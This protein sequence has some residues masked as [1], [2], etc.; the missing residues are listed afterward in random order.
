LWHTILFLQFFFYNL[1]DFL[2]QLSQLSHRINWFDFWEAH[3][4]FEHV[5]RTCRYLSLHTYRQSF[6]CDTVSRTCCSTNFVVDYI[7]RIFWQRASLSTLNALG[8]NEGVRCFPRVLLLSR[9]S[10]VTYTIYKYNAIN[11]YLFYTSRSM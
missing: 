1:K 4:S 10:T 7:A 6:I 8:L 3:F 11:S 9:V 5:V 2:Y